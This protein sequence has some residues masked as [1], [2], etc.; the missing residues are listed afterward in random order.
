M[1]PGDQWYIKVFQ[2]TW[3]SPR[4]EVPF[5]VAKATTMLTRSRAGQHGTTQESTNQRDKTAKNKEDEKDCA[6][7]EAAGPGGGEEDTQGCGR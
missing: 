7:N 3:H 6:D 1:A 2:R 4:R 5:V